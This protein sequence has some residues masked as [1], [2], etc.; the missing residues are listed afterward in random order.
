MNFQEAEI[1]Y[2]KLRWNFRWKND[3]F[4]PQK[5]PKEQMELTHIIPMECYIPHKT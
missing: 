5:D 3:L 1:K 4:L 2:E